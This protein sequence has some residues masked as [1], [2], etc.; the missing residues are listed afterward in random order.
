MNDQERTRRILVVGVDES[1]YEKVEPI[2]TR[3]QF[4]IDRFPR[5]RAVFDLI[6]DVP[7]DILVVGYPLE[8]VKM[9]SFLDRVRHT[10]SH[11]RNTSVLLFSDPARLQ[12]A[13]RFVGDGAN[14]VLSNDADVERISEVVSLLLD[15]APRKEIRVLVRIEVDLA[16]GESLELCQS[17]NISESGILLSC[18]RRYPIGSR[19]DFEFGLEGDIQPIRGTA[20]VVRHT[21]S[22]REGVEGFGARFLS[23]TGNGEKRL[24]RHIEERLG[25][26]ARM[27]R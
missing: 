13:V 16:E 15:I 4:E 17:E 24:A 6:D 1:A 2:L 5:A 19:F 21:D 12:E 14:R 20:E 25:E 27:E 11:S 18:S 22:R 26:D 7:F 10:E 23:I 9:R 3:R 8:E